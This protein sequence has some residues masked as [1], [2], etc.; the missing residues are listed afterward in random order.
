MAGMP[1]PVVGMIGVVRGIVGCRA[2]RA[3]C[4]ARGNRMAGRGGVRCPTSPCAASDI[5][6]PMQQKAGGQEDRDEDESDAESE[7][8]HMVESQNGLSTCYWCNPL[9]DRVRTLTSTPVPIPNPTPGS[10][11]G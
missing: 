6:E 1:G 9:P 11:R 4:K 7:I 2:G 5:V 8:H 3:S 10:R